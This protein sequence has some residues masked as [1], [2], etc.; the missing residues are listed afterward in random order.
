MRIP[1]FQPKKKDPVTGCRTD[2]TDGVEILTGNPK[3]AILNLSG[4]LIIAML[5][6]SSYNVVNAIWVAGLQSGS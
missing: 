1:F 3:K 5:L 6:M 2:T 4:P